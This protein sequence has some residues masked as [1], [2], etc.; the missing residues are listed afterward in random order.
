VRGSKGRDGSLILDLRRGRVE[1][2]KLEEGRRHKLGTQFQVQGKRRLEVRVGVK[3]G[4][5]FES[6]INRR[7][8]RQG[9]QK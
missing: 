2:G 4:P 5:I 3:T 1:R 6:S 9:E 8:R 7:M